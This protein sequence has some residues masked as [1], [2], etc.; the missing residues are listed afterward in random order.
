MNAT[1]TTTTNRIDPQVTCPRCLARLAELGADRGAYAVGNP[2]R[3][4]MGHSMWFTPAGRTAL[5]AAR[6]RD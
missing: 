1:E 5:C 6:R 3:G 4:E 2:A